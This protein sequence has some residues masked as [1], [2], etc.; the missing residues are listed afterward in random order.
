MIKNIHRPQPGV[1]LLLHIPRSI[2]TCIIPGHPS[3][4]SESS[5]DINN[6]KHLTGNHCSRYLS[7]SSS[8]HVLQRKRNKLQSQS[9]PFPSTFISQ[10]VHLP[11]SQF[12][13]SS[14]TNSK[15]PTKEIKLKQLI[16]PFLLTYH[17]DRLQNTTNITKQENLKA[18]QTLNGMIDTIDHIYNRA[19]DDSSIDTTSTTSSSPRMELQSKYTIEFLVP[20]NNDTSN[21][22]TTT[23]KQKEAISTR[24]SVDLNFTSKERNIVQS[25]DGKKGTYSK[26]AAKIVKIKAMKEISKLLR[27]AGL[28]VPDFYDEV[29]DGAEFDL[30]QDVIHRREL[31][32]IH[33]QMILDE[34]DLGEDVFNDNNN[35]SGRSRFDY[36]SSSSRFEKRREPKTEYEKSR[37]R[38][39][40]KVDWKKHAELYDEAM[41]DMKRDLATDGL[42]K[43]NESRKQK[44]VSEIISRIRIYDKS[45]HGSGN[46]NTDDNNDGSQNDDR[47][48]D[49]MVVDPLQQLIAIRR[50]SLLF[51]DS[52]EEL[53]MEEMGKMW[54]NV[55]IVLTPERTKGTGQTGA[56]FSRRKRLREGRESGFKFAY[57]D[58]GKLSVHVPIDFLDD[59]LIGE[60]NRHLDD[61]YDLCVGDVLKQFLPKNYDTAFSGHPRIE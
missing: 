27:V 36:S 39:M 20:S 8:V 4:S 46:T 32:D 35:N 48:E 17:P 31:L 45:I 49:E 26:T 22:S 53:E 56:P 50:M 58:E 23:K 51:M 12:S 40:K 44:L 61:F 28:E 34:L 2:S 21:P 6:S 52:F 33:D 9:F 15:N 55:F 41:E 38:Y 10:K 47:A 29:I 60:L 37:E 59:E 24:R 30:K 1:R 43:M 18:I 19:M 3:M 25:I 11:H 5:H 13:T 7:S 42:I 54:E 57:H 14:A 16:R